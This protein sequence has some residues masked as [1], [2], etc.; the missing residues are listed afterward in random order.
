M[1]NEETTRSGGRWSGSVLCV[2]FS[3][4]TRLVKLSDMKDIQLIKT[5]STSPPKSSNLESV[6]EKRWG[7]GEPRCTWKSAVETEVK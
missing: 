7:T 3:A 2:F 1:V 6:E 5:R 4:L